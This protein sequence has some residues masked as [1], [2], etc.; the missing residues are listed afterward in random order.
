M[1][2]YKSGVNFV[3]VVIVCVFWSIVRY[4]EGR[5]CVEWGGGNK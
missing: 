3:G 5:G 2:F 4:V 1:L